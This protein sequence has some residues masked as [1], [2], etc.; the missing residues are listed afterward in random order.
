[1]TLNWTATQNAA[2]NSSL[3]SW[4]IVGSGSASGY[5][6]VSE[7]RVTINGVNS[8]YRDSSNHTDCYIGTS[9]ASGTISI[10]HNSDGTKSF[11]I[12]IGAGIYNWEINC[13]GSKTFTLDTMTRASTIQSAQDITLGSNC[14]ISWIPTS[15]IFRYKLRFVMGSYSLTTNYIIVPSTSLYTYRL[16]TIDVSAAYAIPNS[17]TGTMTAYLYTYNGD[18]QIGSASSKTFTVTI[19]STCVPTLGSIN[20]TFF[21]DNPVINSWGVA[22][23][24]YT[25]ARFSASASG[26]YGSTINGFSVTSRSYIY[27]QEGTEL[28]YTSDILRRT[29]N[30]DFVISARDSR[31]MESEASIITVNVLEYKRPVIESFSVA[32][33]NQDTRKIILH[34]KWSHTSIGGRNSVQVI[35]YY[36]KDNQSSWTRY[37]GTITNNTAITLT[38]NYEE[39]SSYNFSLAVMDSLGEY[40]QSEGIVSTIGVLV[41]FKAGGMGLAIGKIAED[42]AFAVA[43]DSIFSGEV[44]IKVGIENVPLKTYI[45]NV[46][47]GIYD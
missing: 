39:T 3:I 23:A 10:K 8:Y 16:S 33:D 27:P 7:L 29:G 46:M 25:K 40:A 17:R 12:N 45:K 38:G 28:N 5:V 42:D 9:L 14:S 36:K 26:I 6:T 34:A 1:M 19:P 43:L 18:T 35:L 31:G 30:T 47:N 11:D 4:A 41:D 20:T 44:Y 21:S 24:G 15:T 13:T 2:D 22:V 37:N 32:R